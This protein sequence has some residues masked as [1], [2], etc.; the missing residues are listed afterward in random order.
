MEKQDKLKELVNKLLMKAIN[1]GWDISRD[2]K[3]SYELCPYFEGCSRKV[4]KICV[5]D[6]ETCSHYKHRKQIIRRRN[7]RQN[8]I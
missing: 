2:E 4:Q 8:D 5:S 7:E 6:Y 1:C 3:I